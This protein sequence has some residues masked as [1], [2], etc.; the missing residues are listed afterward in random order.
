MW[1]REFVAQLSFR[2]CLLHCGHLHNSEVTIREWVEWES[3]SF[4]IPP[5]L[6]IC[7]YIHMRTHRGSTNAL[8]THTQRHN[9]HRVQGRRQEVMIR[10]W[11]RGYISQIGSVIFFSTPWINPERGHIFFKGDLYTICAQIYRKLPQVSDQEN[12]SGP[13]LNTIKWIPLYHLH[14]SR[15]SK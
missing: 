10:E 2:H 7:A 14:S 6:Y 3:P 4:P 13:Q 11:Q 9:I 15:W 1:E 5:S 8:C 12:S